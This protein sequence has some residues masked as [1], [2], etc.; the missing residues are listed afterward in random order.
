MGWLFTVDAARVK[1]VFRERVL[2]YQ[3]DCYQV[4]HRNFCNESEKL[5]QQVHESESLRVRMV[6]EARQTFG[7]RAAAQLWRKL[8]LP[9]VPAMAAPLAQ[10][11]LFEWAATERAQLAV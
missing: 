3:R 2:L 1:A 11:D 6:S 7:E 8:D 10:G 4:L 9:L 5:L